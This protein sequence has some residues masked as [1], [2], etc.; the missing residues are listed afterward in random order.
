MSLEPRSTVTEAGLMLRGSFTATSASPPEIRL[1]RLERASTVSVPASAMPLPAVNSATTATTLMTILL[2]ISPSPRVGT[3]AVWSARLRVSLRFS[4]TQRY[5]WSTASYREPSCVFWLCQGPYRKKTLAARSGTVT[6]PAVLSCARGRQT[7]ALLAVGTRAAGLGRRARDGD[8][9]RTR[10]DLRGHGERGRR[11]RLRRHDHK[12]RGQSGEHLAAHLLRALPG[13]GGLLRG[14]LQDR[15]R[16][17]DRRDRRRAALPGGA[18]LAHAPVGLAG[19]VRVDPRRGAS[20]RPR[21]ADRGAGRGSARAR[22]ARAHPRDLRRALSRALCARTA[23]EPRASRHT[24][25]L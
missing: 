13:Q 9:D 2:G 12:R 7:L 1:A 6:S 4:G 15:V 23:G 18:R 25:G 19:D 5:L 14:D 3:G 8:L 22:D 17:R 16:E 11:A 20:L 10:T 21:A 24:R